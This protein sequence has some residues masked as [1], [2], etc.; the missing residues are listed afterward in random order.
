MTYH[1]NGGASSADH[2][3][4]SPWLDFNMTQTWDAYGNIYP[5]VLRDYQRRPAKPCGLGEGAYE[6]GPQYPT[7]PST[8][9]SSGGRPLVVVRRRLPH[10]RERQ[11]LALRHLKAES[12][13]PWQSVAV[14]GR[15]YTA[16]SKFLTDIG[17]WKFAGDRLQGR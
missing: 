11:R 17:W 6:D 4:D 8:R 7:K 14:K 16:A 10:L 5:A 9:S 2:W 12:T 15:D 3:H 1:I 13:Q